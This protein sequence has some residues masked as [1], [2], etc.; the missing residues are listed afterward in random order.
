M[1][2]R[3]IRARPRHGGMGAP[4]H[5][6]VYPS[7]PVDD[8]RLPLRERRGHARSRPISLQRTME[9]RDKCNVPSLRAGLA[10]LSLVRTRTIRSRKSDRFPLAG[11]LAVRLAAQADGA[12]I[13]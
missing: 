11:R 5:P 6:Q 12:S 7:F 13:V 8:A 1:D 4:T 10:A 9:A 3:V 2:R